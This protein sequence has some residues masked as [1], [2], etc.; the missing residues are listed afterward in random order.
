VFIT[1]GSVVFNFANPAPTT[2]QRSFI[3]TNAGS[4]SCLATNS[5]ELTVINQTTGG[6]ATT[7]DLVVYPMS[8]LNNSQVVLPSQ[9]VI[10]VDSVAVYDAAWPGGSAI[11][12][13]PTGATVY[14][15]SVISDPFGS[16]DIT[17]ATIRITD[18]LGAVRVNGAA[19]TQV[20]DS[21]AATK[22]YEYT[23]AVPAGGPA[24]N[25]TIRVVGAEGTEGTISDFAQTA[26]NVFIPM[27]DILMLKSVQVQSDPVN[28][29]VN[30]KAIPGAA[31]LY[32]VTATNQG[33]GATDADT[34]VITDPIPANTELFVGDLGGAGSGPV[35]FSDGATPSGLSYSFI[36]LGSGADSIAFSNDSGAT[37]T[38][39]P[40]P[41][42]NGYDANVT[43][44][45]VSPSGTFN[46]A[47]GPNQPSFNLQFRVRV[48]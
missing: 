33:P 13:T 38:Y 29:A 3:L 35:L 20:A 32:T 9:N 14:L 37:W 15:R 36:N 34:V 2:Y 47:V 40:V 5:W 18:S 26:L 27:P 11:V 19:M 24:G 31:M 8:G 46:G 6:G 43:N 21:G 42:G 16:Y 12:T 25:W 48:K 44:T 45:R 1:S 4:M 28:G 22:T 39:T 30:P 10:N 41:D 23:Y 7:R 17:G